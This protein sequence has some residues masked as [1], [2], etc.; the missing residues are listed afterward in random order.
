MFLAEA[1]EPAATSVTLTVAVSG[2]VVVALGWM[3]RAA[4]RQPRWPDP[5]LDDD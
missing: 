4:Y 3:S 5:E 2:F 1:Y